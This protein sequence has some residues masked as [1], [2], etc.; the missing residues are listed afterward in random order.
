MKRIAQNISVFAALLLAGCSLDKPVSVP[1]GWLTISGGISVNNEVITKSVVE[2]PAEY[3]ITI[4]DSE[5]EIVKKNTYGEIVSAGGKITLDE[6]NYLLSAISSDNE[7]PYSAFETPFYGASQQ[8]TITAGN[9]TN[10]GTITCTMLQAKVTIGYSEEFL[11][12][13]TGDA[14]VSVAV[15]PDAPLNYAL[16]Y[17]GGNPTYEERA[18]YFAVSEDGSSTMAITFKGSVDG[19][20]QRM[21]KTITSLKPATWHCVE[22]IKKIDDDGNATFDVKITDLIE[23]SELKNDIIAQEVIIGEDPDAPKGDGGIKLESTC[24]YDITKPVIVPELGETF[25]LTMKATIPNKVKKFLVEIQSDNEAFITSVKAINIDSAV[26]DLVNP[27][28]GAIEVFTTIL[29]FPYGKDVLGKEVI[30]FDLS[31][32]QVPLL[33][34]KGTHAFIMK[35]TDEQGCKKDIKLELKVE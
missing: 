13:V 31:D 11:E 7:L 33:A 25:N 3:V 24:A 14:L 9:E 18:G 12:M 34:F 21:T 1:Q 20:S 10:L 22:F 26:L 17:N 19:K 4:T 16:N 2:A 32:A 27:S 6:G 29:P 30:D 5:G 28:A 8:F 15:N 35:V 23:D